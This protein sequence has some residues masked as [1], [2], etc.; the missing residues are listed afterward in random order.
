MDITHY[1]KKGEAILKS[2]SFF[3]D[4]MN[5]MKNEEFRYFYKKYF[6]DWTDTQTLIFYMK[7]Y[8]TVEFEYKNRFNAEITDDI[9]TYTL[10]N[11]MTNT[12]TR[13]FAMELFRNYKEPSHSKTYDFRTL[14]QF[15]SPPANLTITNTTNLTITD[16]TNPIIT[17]ATNPTITD[18]T[19]PP[20]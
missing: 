16:A 17:D 19:N 1:K 18:A 15:E 10:H 9:M 8:S 3:K 4:L 13:R 5:V 7:L 11:I 2:N 12:N 14:I 6:H 20:T